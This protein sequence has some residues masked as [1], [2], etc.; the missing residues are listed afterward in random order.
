VDN[1]EVEP[2]TIGVVAVTQ[3]P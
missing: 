3:T 2:K 1:V